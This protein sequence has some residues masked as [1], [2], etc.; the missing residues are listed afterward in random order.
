MSHLLHKKPHTT[1]SRIL[2][3]FIQLWVSEKK[4]VSSLQAFRKR[5]GDAQRI[6]GTLASQ[7]TTVDFAHYRSVLKNQAIVDEAEKLLKDFKPKTYDVSSHIKAIDQFEEKA[8]SKAEATAAE[9]DVELKALQATLANIEEARPF[10]DLTLEDVRKA[11]PQ[12]AETVKT[13]VSKG[14][15]TVPGY[16]EKFG[17]LNIM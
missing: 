6:H 1:L 7:P 2:P 11:H 10:E 8:V 17:D 13:M 14:K 3:K 5:H 12:I 15:W 16:K 9:I 4:T